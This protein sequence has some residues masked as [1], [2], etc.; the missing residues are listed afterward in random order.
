VALHFLGLP[1]CS[2]LRAGVS[3]SAGRS[4]L[5]R[6]SARSPAVWRRGGLRGRR[7]GV[8]L[9]L[10]SAALIS[11]RGLSCSSVADGLDLGCSGTPPMLARADR[12]S[13]HLTDL[14]SAGYAASGPARQ[15]GELDGVGNRRAAR[16]VVEVHVDVGLIRPRLAHPRQPGPQRLRPIAGPRLSR[17]LV[18][19]QIAPGRGTS[20]VRSRQLSNV[21]RGGS[22]C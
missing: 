8:V 16:V 6:L 15:A 5:C 4:D 19:P 11:M 3:R 7:F 20:G 13:R 12:G 17:A 1:Q 21:S 14:G 22:C 10:F 2:S 18:E 9:G